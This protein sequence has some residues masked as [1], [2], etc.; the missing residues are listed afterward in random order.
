MNQKT[1]GFHP[2]RVLGDVLAECFKPAVDKTNFKLGRVVENQEA[3]SSTTSGSVSILPWS[4][5]GRRRRPA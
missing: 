5:K 3:D 1:R 2:K 4:A